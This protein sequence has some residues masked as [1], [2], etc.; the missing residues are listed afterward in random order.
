V[1]LL[2]SAAG[3]ILVAL[4]G[5]A[6]SWSNPVLIVKA[7]RH[8]GDSPAMAS[9]LLMGLSWGLAGVAMLPL[10]AIGELF[11]TR[12]LLIVAG[13]VP[14]LGIGSCFRLPKDNAVEAAIAKVPPAR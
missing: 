13:I 8:A 10:G 1:L 5:M 14:L 12:T 9:S 3:W 2:P 4:S 7:Q 11:G 6:L